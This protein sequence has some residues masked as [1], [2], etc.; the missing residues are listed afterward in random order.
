MNRVSKIGM[1]LCALVCAACGQQKS[2]T[3]AMDPMAAMN[4]TPVVSVTGAVREQVARDA[5]YSATVQ[6]NVINNIAPLSSGRIQKL[7]V[8]VGDFVSAGQ[9][10][11]EM[12]RVQLDQAALRLK[13]DETELA[14]VKQLL[15]EGGVSQSDYES[16]ELA[17]NVSKSSYDNLV[18]NTILRAPVSG[19]VSARNYDRGDLYSMS[20]PIYTVQQITPVKLLV[21]ISEA[22][23]TRVK[24][25]DKVTLTADALPGRTYTGTIVRLYPTID[26]ASHTF[27][28]EV[29]VANENRE[30]RP[31]MYARV[32]VDFGAVESIVVPDAAVL[33]QQGSGQRIVFVLN[34]DDTVSIRPVEPGRHFGTRYEILSGLEEGEQVLTGGHTNLKSGDKVEVKR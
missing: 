20:Q 12:D 25:G 24:R 27:S 18:E 8:E 7:N 9:I 11:A 17:F 14:R 29:R 34:A 2:G 6:A 33:K 10:L 32:S 28:A 3:P 1:A 5:V 31:G 30:L 23:Y 21:P 19:V 13:N 4:A 26:P 16:L 22:D 15:A